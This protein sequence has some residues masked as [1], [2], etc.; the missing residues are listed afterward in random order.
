[1]QVLE[2]GL[3]DVGFKP[4]LLREKLQVLSSPRP[5]VAALGGGACGESVSQPFLPASMYTFSHLPHV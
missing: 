4:L 2:V 3:P 5:W 1:M